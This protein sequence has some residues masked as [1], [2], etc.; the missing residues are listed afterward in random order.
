V[1]VDGR[2]S[3]KEQVGAL[4][5]PEWRARASADVALSCYWPPS[6]AARKARRRTTSTAANWAARVGRPFLLWA[7]WISEP[8]AHF[9]L[10]GLCAPGPSP[11]AVAAQHGEESTSA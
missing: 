5:V 8:G 3:L 2:A 10:G 11:Q 7:S 9:A 1:D 4:G 6:R